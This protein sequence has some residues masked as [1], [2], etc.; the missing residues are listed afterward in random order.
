M[1]RRLVPGLR[2]LGLISLGLVLA[3]QG[4]FL[5]RYGTTYSEALVRAGHGQAWTDAVTVVVGGSVALLVLVVARL[6]GL[7]L[8]V[9]TARET[10]GAPRPG[11]PR[12]VVVVDEPRLRD[13]VRSWLEMV[14]VIGPAMALALTAQE[15][16]ERVA[17]GL[18]PRGPLILL[19][20][21][22]AMA[23]PIVGLVAIG[24]AFVAA[25]LG[26]R[27]EVLAARLRAARA[28]LRAPRSLA[29]AAPGK[30]LPL[31]PRSLLARRLGRRAPPP[32]IAA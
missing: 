5:A 19:G 31:V 21:E 23:L 29:T 11:Y 16:I 24:V 27:H 10:A 32:A 6:H 17:A 26:W 28:G 1:V 8:L 12:T 9:R 22:Y 25:L 14:L 3:H 30:P 13:F 15:N 20:P 7:G 2:V 4:L 18:G